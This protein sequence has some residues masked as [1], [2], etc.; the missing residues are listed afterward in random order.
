MSQIL[1]HRIDG[2]GEPLMLLNGGLMTIPSW[3]PLMPSLTSRSRVVRCDLRGQLLSPGD[4]PVT[5]SGHVEDL[6]TLLDELGVDEIDVFGTSF[7]GEV[8]LLLAAQHPDRVRSLVVLS[9]TDRLTEEMHRQSASL[10]DIAETAAAGGDR[11]AVFRALVPNTFSPEWIAQQ[12][13][14][15]VEVRASQIGQL[16]LPFFQGLAGL[17][18]AL[19]TL[20]L[21]TALPRITCPTMIIGAELDHVFPVEHSRALADAITSAELEIIEGSGHAAIVE[22][23]G[24]V[25]ELLHRFLSRH[26]GNANA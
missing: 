19:E 4:S 18:R 12:P 3:E 13:P 26:R 16:P 14:D 8:A 22:A 6:I 21:T 24:R 2:D 11:G 23:P 20:D 15:F 10:I 7:G 9:S 25:I 1:N 5:L 17:M